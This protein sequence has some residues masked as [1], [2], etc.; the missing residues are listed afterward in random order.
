[1]L[2]GWKIIKNHKTVPGKW[3][4]SLANKRLGCAAQS[5]YLGAGEQRV[6]CRMCMFFDLPPR[7]IV[8]KT[9]I[10][11]APRNGGHEQLVIYSNALHGLDQGA[12]MVLPAYLGD[13]E[14][15]A[16]CEKEGKLPVQWHDMSSYPSVFRD[17]HEVFWKDT[18]EGAVFAFGAPIG[19]T[20]AV[21]EVG[22]YNVSVA[23]SAE[24]LAR[25]SSEFSVSP[26]VMHTVTSAYPGM[27]FL[28]FRIARDGKNEPFAFSH[29]TKTPGLLVA[30]T[31]H[32]HG[33]SD[34]IERLAAAHFGTATGPG[35]PPETAIPPGAE[36]AIQA[37]KN[38]H[39]VLRTL[40]ADWDHEIYAINA[41]SVPSGPGVELK[42]AMPGRGGN[43]S[44][45]RDGMQR[46]Q[47][48]SVNNILMG[49]PV[50]TDSPRALLAVKIGKAF[51]FN[52]DIAFQTGY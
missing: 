49:L 40:H 43:L 17:L 27:G 7:A 34:E 16:H 22:S 37:R 11:V 12:T 47:W 19:A 14:H 18:R 44:G 15:I 35:V 51:P 1:M 31:M 3:A 20:L 13:G 32:L 36:T 6:A 42:Y 21:H 41:I 23:T 52:V 24:D 5:V 30:P 38:A 2:Y 29:P 50:S 26:S 4:S 48:G 46:A 8:S 28:V 33:D 39:D 45:D 25:L 10:L 9:Q